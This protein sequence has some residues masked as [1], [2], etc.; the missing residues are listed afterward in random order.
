MNRAFSV[1]HSKHAQPSC[2]APYTRLTPVP[3]DQAFPTLQ[4]LLILPPSSQLSVHS[5]SPF[6]RTILYPYESSMTFSFR[7][8]R[9]LYESS[10]A[11][12]FCTNR[13]PYE[14][15]TFSFC[16]NRPRPCHSGRIFLRTN[17]FVICT[18]RYPYESLSVRIVIRTNR[19]P[20]VHIYL[21]FFVWSFLLAL[22][23]AI[24]RMA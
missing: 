20:T 2:P 14:S 5:G 17:R 24:D 11:F 18:V 9:C 4:Q 6:I 10:M 19:Y 13:Y 8:N 16:T 15:S 22:S 7:T 3:S 1:P 23:R 12:S 21:S